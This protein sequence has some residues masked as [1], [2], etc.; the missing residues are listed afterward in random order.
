[1]DATTQLWIMITANSILLGISGFLVKQWINSVKEDS[2][3]NQEDLKEHKKEVDE[4][5][6][7]LTTEMGKRKGE[8]A[9]LKKDME[10]LSIETN[11]NFENVKVHMEYQKTALDDIRQGVNNKND[12][13]VKALISLIE[14]LDKS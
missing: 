12:V 9:L 5:F 8:T 1:M 4:Q 6:G 10:K 11:K 7:K 3:S 2:K 13:E 14:K